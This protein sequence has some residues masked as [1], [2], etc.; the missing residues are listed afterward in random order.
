[1]NKRIFIIIY[2]F[3]ITI[4]TFMIVLFSLKTYTDVQNVFREDLNNQQYIKAQNTEEIIKLVVYGNTEH[5]NMPE[6]GK[7]ADFDVSVLKNAVK[8]L[9]PED[10]RIVV[11]DEDNKVVIDTESILKYGHKADR[12]LSNVIDSNNQIN[13][14][15]GKKVILNSHIIDENNWKCISITEYK[16]FLDATNGI[17][18]KIIISCIIFILLGMFLAIYITCLIY[19]PIN[20]LLKKINSLIGKK[21]EKNTKL[22]LHICDSFI[23]K[24]SKLLN[25]QIVDASDDALKSFKPYFVENKGNMIK[26]AVFYGSN[27]N[28]DLEG[29]VVLFKLSGIDVDN[30]YVTWVFNMINLYLEEYMEQSYDFVVLDKTQAL[31]VI[32]APIDK[33]KKMC[34]I[35]T[36]DAELCNVILSSYIG[37][38]I[39]DL[40]QI[41]YEYTHCHKM[42]EYQIMYNCG[43]VFDTQRYLTAQQKTLNFDIKDMN[44]LIR[45][46]IESDDSETVKNGIH[47]YLLQISDNSAENFKSICIR[48][49][50]ALEKVYNDV[51]R[52]EK[53]AKSLREIDIS[54]SYADNLC[55]IES[56]II[57]ISEIMSELK[58]GRNINA[59][60]ICNKIDRLI[61]NNIAN[62]GLSPLFIATELGYPQ[63]QLVKIYKDEKGISIAEVIN[64]IRM[65]NVAKLLISEDYT[66]KEIMR[67]NGYTSESNFYKLFKKYYHV[68]PKEYKNLKKYN[69]E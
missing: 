35:I 67:R 65:E 45:Q 40:T 20:E 30:R 64:K 62:D 4:L 46:I 55:D 50:N 26:N 42:S 54:I 39:T 32:D 44:A 66:I 49:V 18:T 43:V 38:K 5:G 23:F 9:N 1:M 37:R 69:E 58:S 41:N 11:L 47:N 29:T 14:I 15:N 3:I 52:L 51:L 63:R 33:I 56:S 28:V 19:I 12:D 31:A 16:N 68:T 48:L 24:P 34:H 22:Y 59:G 13:E 17:K 21:I 36:D 60:S 7:T 61:W 6:L 2:T 10:M 25:K 8:S 57:H 27:D 53:S